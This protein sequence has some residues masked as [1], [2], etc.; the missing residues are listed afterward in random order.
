MQTTESYSDRR[1]N[2]MGYDRRGSN[3]RNGNPRRSETRRSDARLNRS[4]E[5]SALDYD[6]KTVNVSA[7]GVYLEVITNDIGVFLPGTTIP[8]QINTVTKIPEDRERKIKLSGRG[9]VLR[10]C[11]FESPD[12]ANSLGVALKF[13]EKLNTE[14]DND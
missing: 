2:E 7:K 8:L 11:M 12:H 3:S 6:G 1:R 13:T 9:T 5:V 4:F 14:L 10:N